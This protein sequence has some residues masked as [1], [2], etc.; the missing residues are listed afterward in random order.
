MTPVL[1]VL[2][3]T[4]LFGLSACG[5]LP[6]RPEPSVPTEAR[7][8]VADDVPVPVDAPPPPA[9]APSPPAPPAEAPSI[10][11]TP[12]RPVLV[13]PEGD[14]DAPISVLDRYR[15]P[16][17]TRDQLHAV[18]WIQHGADQGQAW[19]M[20]LL[21]TLYETGLGFPQSD[22]DAFRW[23]EAAA[24]GDDPNAQYRLGAM[25]HDGRGTSQDYAAA[26][27]WLEK[28]VA[29]EQ[30]DAAYLLGNMHLFGRG[31]E[32]DA[33]AA[34]ELWALAAEAGHADALFNLGMAYLHGNGV[35]KKA[36]TAAKWLHQA[37]FAFLEQGRMDEA[38]RAHAAL[39]GI[40]PDGTPTQELFQAIQRTR[41]RTT[42]PK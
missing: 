18:E 2:L 42:P 37:G 28:A 15:T 9:P 27:G 38:E 30:P 29:Q 26:R 3:A 21:G 39:A 10:E 1:P 19:A 33:A 20:Y 36:R 16:V 35:A 22:A 4:L 17:T 32:K 8:P 24:R 12:S 34:V 13:P 40:K 7:A 5:W 14:L 41:A 25:Y 31:M 11:M 6:S 23:Y